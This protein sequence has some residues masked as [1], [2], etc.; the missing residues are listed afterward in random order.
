MDPRPTCTLRT[1]SYLAPVDGTS[2]TGGDA[3]ASGD[4]GD[5]IGTE[6][7]ESLGHRGRRRRRV[8]EPSGRMRDLVELGRAVVRRAIEDDPELEA[9]LARLGMLN[10]E[11]AV[12]PSA[13]PVSAPDPRVLL[14]NLVTRVASSGEARLGAAG[15]GGLE[16]LTAVLDVRDVRNGEPWPDEICLAF[17]DIEA[18]TT[19]TDEHGDEAALDMLRR[20]ALSVEPA[21]RGR[22]GTIVKRMG[23]GLF[24]RFPNAT[25]GVAAVCDCFTALAA[26]AAG[27]PDTPI[28]IR[29]GLTLG[30]PIRSGTDL[31]G[32]DVNLAAR[33]ADVAV[34]GEVLMTAAARAE[35]GDDLT[36]VVFED[37]GPVDVRG[38]PDPVDVFAARCQTARTD[39]GS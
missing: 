20:H 21:I 33:L 11:A 25:A 23:D 10:P 12:D 38:L 9:K 28:R 36:R 39:L 17:T 29:A 2:G 6:V 7:A 31:V 27:H 8:V 5:E 37:R 35:V 14:G 26:D 16:A 15:I 34:A 4:V 30:R 18:F 3:A 1:L 13:A 22:G 24:V 32:T 19:F